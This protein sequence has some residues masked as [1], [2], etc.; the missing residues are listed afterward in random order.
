MISDFLTLFSEYGIVIFITVWGAV[1]AIRKTKTHIPSDMVE[2]LDAMSDTEL[3]E[4][5][6]SHEFFQN[7]QMKM[8]ID[9]PV[10]YFSD[11]LGRNLLYRDLLV[12]LYKSF[13]KNTTKFVNNLNFSISEEEWK[14]GMHDC[15]YDS[16][17]EFTSRCRA[18]NVPNRAIHLFNTFLAPHMS[19]IH[20]T[21]VDIHRNSIQSRAD[22]VNKTS[23]MMLMLDFY[24][25][26]IIADVKNIPVFNGELSGMTYRN[27]PLS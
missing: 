21:I 19:T 9:L 7:L 23:F 24:L 25:A 26:S 11:D 14:K 5:L 22:I 10:E 12:F 8:K 16:I 1:Y 3:R 2:K 4:K 13:Y 18:E 6:L 15:I 17:R 27:V 20:K